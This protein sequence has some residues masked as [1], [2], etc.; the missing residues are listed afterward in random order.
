MRQLHLVGFTT[1]HKQL[2]FSAR[3]GTK[4]GGFTVALDDHLV[5]LID[6]ALRRGD[7]DDGDR[8]AQHRRFARQE[9]LLSPREIQSRLRSGSTLTQVA[10]D[11]GVDEDWIGRFAAPILAE[12]AQVIGRARELRYATPRK[13]VSAQPLGTSVRWNV[14]DRGVRLG[15]DDFDGAWGAFQLRDGSWVVRFVFVS[16]QR[17]QIAEWEVD[18]PSATVTARNRLASNLG[19]I[20]PRTRPPSAELLVPAPPSTPP[21]SAAAPSEETDPGAI[22]RPAK[23]AAKKRPAKKRAAKRRPAKRAGKKKAGAKSASTRRP[24]RKKAAR[25]PARSAKKSAKKSARQAAAEKATRTKATAP[26]KRA[27]KKL[28]GQRKAATRVASKRATSKKAAP[29]KAATK[30]RATKTAAAKG[31]ATKRTATTAARR[32]TRPVPPAAAALPPATRPSPRPRDTAPP[33]REPRS[34]RRARARQTAEEVPAAQLF[35]ASLLAEPT[36]A[37]EHTEPPRPDGPLA[38]TEPPARDR[39]VT[40]RADRARP[41][42]RSE[43]DTSSRRRRATSRH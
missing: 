24:V 39:V 1:D 12:Q 7:G 2:I 15:D 22:A 26:R 41:P 42:T 21:A 13:G 4:S 29:K 30:G 3:K 27:A 31:R 16:R 25:S 9:S 37:V 32:Q 35:E 20:A 8:L 17:S 14:A 38:A 40:I 36:G 23:R 28:R 19:Y 33:P 5:G 10:S 6:E 34:L 43:L 18:F 11:A